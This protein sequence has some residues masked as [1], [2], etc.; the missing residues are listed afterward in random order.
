MADTPVQCYY[1]GQLF[2]YERGGRL[3]I[4]QK[5]SVGSPASFQCNNCERDVVWTAGAGT[6]KP[7]ATTTTTTTTKK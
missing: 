3:V 7:V 1:C 6:S 2:G 5:A 4:N